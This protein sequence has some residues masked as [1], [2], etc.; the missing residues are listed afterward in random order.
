MVHSSLSAFI[1]VSSLTVVPRYFRVTGRQTDS[2][3]NTIRVNVCNGGGYN[4]MGGSSFNVF[5][6]EA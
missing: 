2:S 3:D 1:P 5:E 6:M 4:P